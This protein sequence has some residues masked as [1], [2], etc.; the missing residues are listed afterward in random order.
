[1]SG[2]HSELA[3]T[4]ILEIAGWLESGKVSCVDLTEMHLERISAL[5]REGPR[6]NSIIELNPDAVDIAASLDSELRQGHRRGQL[7]G[8]PILVKDNINTGDRMQTSS[9]SL[10]MV[11]APA[12]KDAPLVA[13]LR[14]AGALILGKANLTEWGD[15]RSPKSIDGWSGRGGQTRNPYVLDRTPQGS[16]GGSAVAVA[17][18]LCAGAVGTETQASIVKPA[19]VSSVVGLKPTVSTVPRDGLIPVSSSQGSPGPIARS[20]SDTALLLSAMADNGIDYQAALADSD[21]DGV[22]IGVLRGHPFSGFNRYAEE[23]LESSLE[24]L[25]GLGAI[26]IDAE[27]PSMSE[28]LDVNASDDL[29]LWEFKAGI[30]SYLQRRP[31]VPMNSL[32]DLMAFNVE[33][34]DDEMRFFGQEVWER[35]VGKGPLSEPAYLEALER[36]RRL[37][38]EEGID[39]AADRYGVSAFVLAADRPP[40]VR[41]PAVEH[42]PPSVPSALPAAM[43]GYPIISVPAGFAFDELPIGMG[44]FG[45]AGSE[46]HLLGIAHAFEQASEASRPPRFLKTLEVS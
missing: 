46:S 1:M 33:H 15:F 14:R 9:G 18:G 10:A 37:A 41:D 22:R 39:L 30:D 12:E 40:H 29:Y 23:I 32:E 4:T 38:R 36:R 17:A 44:L 28:I 16:S 3:S 6:L 35:A 24:T 8:I 27:I 25:L 20:V 19:A 11:G 45:G 42:N 7:H 2:P 34:S 26:L 13:N 31:G 43:A 21:L 5:D